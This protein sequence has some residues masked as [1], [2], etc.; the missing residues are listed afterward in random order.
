M[1]VRARK[2]NL[3]EMKKVLHYFARRHIK[4]V[5]Q[6]NSSRSSRNGPGVRE[7]L[8][9]IAEYEPEDFFVCSSL[10]NI[11]EA[12]ERF[13]VPPVAAV[14]QLHRRVFDDGASFSKRL[15]T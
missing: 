11:F 14:G 15:R 3:L 2:L 1:K 9:V 10:I 8:H 5:S 7:S 12:M 13:N 4:L 6:R